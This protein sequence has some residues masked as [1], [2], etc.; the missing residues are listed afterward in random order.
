M[1]GIK[2]AQLA[3]IMLSAS[4]LTIQASTDCPRCPG[5]F[6]GR[7]SGIKF[8]CSEQCGACSRGY[9]T[10]L[11][12]C[13]KCESLLE[14][15]DWLFLGFMMICVMV[16]NFYAID[17]FHATERKIWFYHLSVIVESFFSFIFMILSFEPQGKLTLHTCR[18]QSI[19]DWYT[20][21]YNPKPDYVNALRCTQEAVYPL[22]T[23]IF[24]YLIYCLVL[25]VI[26][27]GVL[28]P[29]LLK[30]RTLKALYA[31]LYILPVVGLVH[32]CLAGIIY[33]TYPHL[34]IFLSLIGVVI[35]L[36]TLNQDYYNN[37]KK[38]RH[39]GVLA[40]YC[41][42]H[43]YGIISITEMSVPYR[44]GP[45][46]VLVFLPVVFYSISRKFTN[47]EKFKTF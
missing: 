44:D 45:V 41:V 47:A 32:T 33:Y 3:L 19:K 8:N 29:N 21:F 26:C 27:R 17:W 35:F 11:Y 46:L 39:I 34:M 1:Q 25:M 5:I 10:N 22:Y 43:G 24:V 16:L 38:P 37:L 12:H 18:V 42:A 36:S 14:L 4:M 40:C 28:L 20:V 15:Y 9:R 13:T 7:P 31:G 23:S 6:C 2:F 30:T